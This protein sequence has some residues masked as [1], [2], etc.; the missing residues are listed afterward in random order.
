MTALM[1]HKPDN[2]ITFLEE[3]LCKVRTSNIDTYEWNTF[4]RL[5]VN[6]EDKTNARNGFAASKP[7]PPIGA[8]E[9][10]ETSQTDGTIQQAAQ[11][12][13]KIVSKDDTGDVQTQELAKK[14]IMFVLGELC[15]IFVCWDFTCVDLI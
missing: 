11:E 2:P 3:C 7:L 15:I 13:N 14:S 4:N 10:G 8:A 5:C 9:N 1:Y 12:E 6:T